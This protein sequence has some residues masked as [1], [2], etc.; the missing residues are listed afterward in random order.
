MDVGLILSQMVASAIFLA[1]NSSTRCM[2]C[3]TDFWGSSP[4]GQVV[5]HIPMFWQSSTLMSSA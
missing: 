3:C 1:L 5:E 2:R 4:L